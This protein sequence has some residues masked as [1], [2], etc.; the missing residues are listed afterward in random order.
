MRIG[1]EYS[2]LL[3]SNVPMWELQYIIIPMN[4]YYCE[5]KNK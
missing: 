5:S 4:N 2:V 3:A 1:I